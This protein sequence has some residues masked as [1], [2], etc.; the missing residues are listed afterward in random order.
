MKISII[1][2]VFNVEKYI[3]KCITTVCNQKNTD[4]EILIINDGT[5]DNSIEI[6]KQIDDNR[7]R[8]INQENGGL[9]SARNTGIKNA[10]G[11][12]IAFVDS[13]DW[14]DVNIYKKLY[15]IAID[16]DCDIVQCDFYKAYSEFENFNLNTEK[17]IDILNSNQALQNLYNEKYI[18]TI[19]VWNK[20]YK[21]ELFNNIEFPKGKLHEDEFTTYKLLYKAKKIGITN[22]SLYYYRQTPNS[23][24][25]KKFNIKRLDILEALEERIEFM[26]KINNYDLYLKSLQK[27][28]FLLRKMFFLC[29]TEIKNNKSLLKEIKQKQ[30]TIFKG[31]LFNK[32]ISIKN[33]I[34]F[35]IFLLNNDLYKFIKK[36]DF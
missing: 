28:E 30:I 25:N 4:I 9:S 8:I 17:R 29:K 26:N 23:I 13:D 18:Q 20:I 35:I 36:Q 14:V 5:L 3:Y 21:K 12:Y 7:I 33:K 32:N 16:N 19:V 15:N 1:I 2:P 24:M 10:K 27:Y 11:Q 34:G 22:E 6:V 31:Y